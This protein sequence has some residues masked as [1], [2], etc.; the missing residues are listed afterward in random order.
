MARRDIQV[1][2]RDPAGTRLRVDDPT[3]LAAVLAREHLDQIAFLHF[4]NRPPPSF[5]R[6]KV[7][8]DD[9]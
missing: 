4:H 8:K 6:P 9:L 1:L 7:K 3:L 2:D 5:S